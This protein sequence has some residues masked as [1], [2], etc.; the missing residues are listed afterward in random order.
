MAN[1]AAVMPTPI[2]KGQNVLA[3][4]PGRY[5]VEEITNEQMR[6][7]N[8]PVHVWHYE[9]SVLACV[10]Q[11]GATDNYKVVVVYPSEQAPQYNI[12]SWSVWSGWKPIATATPPAV[13]DLPLA[14]GVTPYLPCK[15]WKTQDNEVKTLIRVSFTTFSNPLPVATLP[16][17]YRPRHAITVLSQI[18]SQGG[19]TQAHADL[20]Q[21]GDIWL[22]QDGAA[23]GNGSAIIEPFCFVSA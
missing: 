17:G 15:Y 5:S 22:Y 20:S 4:P 12:L 19:A 7:M 6:A 14:A 9:I 8:L 10:I 13:Y 18:Y 21:S 23:S 1:K 3:L 16:E 2:A 11:A